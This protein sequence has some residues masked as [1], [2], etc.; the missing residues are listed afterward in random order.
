MAAPLTS[1]TKINSSHLRWT[2]AALEAF[3]E[4]K[5]RFTSA[6]ILRHPDPERPFIVEVDA[7]NTGTGAILSQRHGSPPK[8]YP[9]AYFSRKLSPAKQN[10]EGNGGVASL[11]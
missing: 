3:T 8:L 5:S 7:S 11:A 4:L 6:P 1:M 9:C 2:T 10:E